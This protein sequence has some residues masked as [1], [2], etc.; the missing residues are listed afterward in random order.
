MSSRIPERVL[1]DCDGIADVVLPLKSAVGTWPG[2]H[3]W[4]S[5]GQW[6][7]AVPFCY[8]DGCARGR[9]GILGP[10][11]SRERAAFVW[12]HSLRRAQFSRVQGPGQGRWP[13]RTVEAEIHG[14]AVGAAACLVH[15]RHMPGGG[16][17][18]AGKARTS[19]GSAPGQVIAGRT[20]QS[21]PGQPRVVL[22]LSA[23]SMTTCMAPMSS[24]H[25]MPVACRSALLRLPLSLSPAY[26]TGKI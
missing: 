16:T 22:A 3:S 5:R 19:T 8:P 25:A 24:M 11:S 20:W 6:D 1:R 26:F 13:Y 2:G 7:A 21:A 14:H 4:M 12:G 10:P 23:S 15:P 18:H 9:T 17:A